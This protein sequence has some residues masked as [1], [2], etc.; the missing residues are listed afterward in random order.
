LLKFKP[1]AE[2]ALLK[3]AAI[4]NSG[5]AVKERNLVLVGALIPASSPNFIKRF[6]R[7]VLRRVDAGTN[8]RLRS[9]HERALDE[10]SEGFIHG[11]QLTRAAP[12]GGG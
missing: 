8:K 4:D 1:R 7:S 11:S 9:V 2:F 10:L 6:L 5:A 12:L 3:R